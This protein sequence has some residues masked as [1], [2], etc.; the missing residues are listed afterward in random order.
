MLQSMGCTATLVLLIA[1]NILGYLVL[2]GIAKGCPW[3]ECL[4]MSLRW[5]LEEPATLMRLFVAMAIAEGLLMLTGLGFLIA[6]LLWPVLGVL[7]AWKQYRHLR[8][9]EPPY[10]EDRCLKDFL[11]PSN[12]LK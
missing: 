8:Y 10:Q 3:K 4:R 5:I 6:G 11:F 2:P 9:A 7:L 12:L 1:A